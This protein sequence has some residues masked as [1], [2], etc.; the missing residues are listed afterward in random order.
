M[1]CDFS[2]A[3]PDGAVSTMTGSRI[4]HRRRLQ[5]GAALLLVGLAVVLWLGREW[6]FVHRRHALRQWL[7]SN[8]GGPSWQGLKD[9][10]V[11][12]PFWRS[13]M[14]DEPMAGLRVPALNRSEIN[15]LTEAFPESYELE[16]QPGAKKL[17]PMP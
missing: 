13:W 9:E 2:R 11:T 17:T 4:D 12:I 14:G 8:G 10:P 7:V 16:L 1:R 15:R 3:R 5:L 6:M